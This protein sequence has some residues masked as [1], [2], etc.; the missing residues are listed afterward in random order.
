MSLFIEG[1]FTNTVS[2]RAACTLI[3]TTCSKNTNRKCLLFMLKCLIF[4][5]DDNINNKYLKNVIFAHK[6][7]V[8][9]TWNLLL[10]YFYLS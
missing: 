6:L 10:F 3:A 9:Q 7:F 4:L 5:R 1:L 2:T 8:I